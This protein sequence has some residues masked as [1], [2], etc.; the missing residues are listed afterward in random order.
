MLCF[1]FF[2][3]CLQL[4]KICT[5]QLDEWAAAEGPVDLAAQGKD[6]SFEFST[7]LLVRCRLV[8]L[9]LLLFLLLLL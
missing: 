5:T 9:L 1:S 6:L 4:I 8:L 2:S 7:Q 3:C